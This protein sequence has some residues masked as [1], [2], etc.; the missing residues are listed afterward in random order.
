MESVDLS[1]LPEHVRRGP[2]F[3]HQRALGATFYDDYGR[4]WTAGFGDVDREYRA[5]REGCGLW[6]VS[7]L[8]KWHVT[9]P[10]TVA[11]LDRLTTR[12]MA[13]EEPGQ[14][15]YVLILDE[16]GHI[17]DEGTRYLVG[18]E[19]AWFVGN[20][21]RPALAAHIARVLEEFDVSLANRTDELA[22][23]AIQGPE[24]P[25]LLA[26]LVDVDL[27]SLRYYRCIAG[28]SAAGVPAMISRTGF[29]GELGYE[30]FVA[31]RAEAV[32]EAIVAA[33]ATPI[34]LDAVEIARVEVG[35]V[36]ADEDY[37]SFES[38]PYEVGLGPFIDLDGHGFVG[39]DAAAA[40]SQAP[41]RE[42]MT[43]VFDGDRRPAALAAVTVDDRV[44][45]EV[46][47]V[48]RSPRFGMLGLA[49]MDA[50]AALDGT[51]VQADGCRAIVRPRPL[52]AQDRPRL[53][54][55][56]PVRAG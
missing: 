54:P 3:E 17:V 5:I 21:D 35:F 24:A 55:S 11:A 23:L 28:I 31:E 13:G 14:V 22:C 10:D 53:D 9:G 12:P 49:T 45:G 26:S 36:V 32:W 30:L 52:D 16:Q 48:E 47:S 15:R 25:A 4:L 19:E 46:R 29:S 18:P 40:A 39:R 38:D 20:E 37:V 50:D 6:D 7:P 1:S 56:A 42:L 43:L 34:G 27:A 2:L 41:H 44:V 33:G 51:F 8:S